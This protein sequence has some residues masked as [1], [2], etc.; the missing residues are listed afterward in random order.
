MWSETVNNFVQ[1]TFGNPSDSRTL[2]LFWDIMSQ[3]GYPLAKVVLA[4]IKNNSKHIPEEMEKA[5][6]ANPEIMQMIQ[7]MLSQ[8]QGQGG[9]RPNSG[10]VG[11]GATHAANVERTNQRDAAFNE[12][13]QTKPV[14]PQQMSASSGGI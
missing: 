1:G 6:L 9:A 5:I 11:N 10:P 3:Q 12:N 13:S 4:G 2:T 7:S 14:S 8:N